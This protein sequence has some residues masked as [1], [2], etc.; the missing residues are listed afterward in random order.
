M[1]VFG[2]P[3]ILPILIGL[4]VASTVHPRPELTGK[5]LVTKKPEA[6]GPVEAAQLAENQF[7]R[8]LSLFRMLNPAS[9]FPVNAATVVA[10]VVG[11]CAWF[12]PA[13]W[14]WVSAAN[15]FGVMLLVAGWSAA[16]RGS[17]PNPQPPITW[18]AARAAAAG[19]RGRVIANAAGGACAGVSVAWLLGW[20]FASGPVVDVKAGLAEAVPGAPLEFWLPSGSGVLALVAAGV[21]G[22]VLMAARPVREAALGHWRQL[23]QM[24]EEW[25]ERWVA[26]KAASPFLEDFRELGEAVVLTFD[27]R[28]VTSSADVAG[29][30]KKNPAVFDQSRLTSFSTLPKL[31]DGNAPMPGTVDPRRFE[32]TQWPSDRLPAMHEIDADREQLTHVIGCALQAA[33][34]ATGQDPI[35]LADLIDLT[36]HENPGDKIWAATFYGSAGMPLRQT[37]APALGRQL[38]T[39]TLADHRAAGEAGVM[40][41][42]ALGDAQPRLDLFPAPSPDQAGS[43]RKLH[44]APE[45]MLAEAGAAELDKLALEDRWT[46]AWLSSLATNV[47]TPVTRHLYKETDTL[48]N[49]KTVERQAF[50]VRTGLTPPELMVPKTEAALASSRGDSFVSITSWPAGPFDGKPFRGFGK[51]PEKHATLFMVHTSRYPVPGIPDLAP[52]GD[53]SGPR[54]VLAGKLAKAFDEA[55][56]AR[57]EIQSCEPI[58]SQGSRKH[59]WRVRLWLYGGVTLADVRKASKKLKSSLDVAYLRIVSAPGGCEVIVGAD[60]NQRGIALAK[61]SHRQ[62]LAA[63]DWEEAFVEAGV[64]SAA[65]EPPTFISAAQMPH[66]ELVTR[67]V[68]KVPTGKSV[69][70]VRAAASKLRIATRNAFVD[71]RAEKGSP[72]QVQV[73][74]AEASPLRFP[75]PFRFDTDFQVTDSPFGTGVDGAPIALNRDR[76]AHL[77]IYGTSGGGKSALA[78]TLIVGCLLSGAQV[79]VAD[80]QKGAADFRFAEPWLSGTATTSNDVLALMQHLTDEKNR[81]VKLNSAHGCG[82]VRELPE[83]VRPPTVYFFIDEFFGIIANP[84]KPA[85]RP[86]DDPELEKARQELVAKLAVAKQ[87][88]YLTG[89]FAAEARSADIHLVVMTQKITLGMLDNSAAGP[90]ALNDLKTNLNAILLGKAKYGEKQSALRAPEDAPDVGEEVPPG[91]G[92]FEPVEGAAQIFQGWYATTAEYAAHLAARVPPSEPVDLSGY[93]G[94]I[95]KTAAPVGEFTVVDEDMSEVVELDFSEFDFTFDENDLEEGLGEPEPAPD[96]EDWMDDGDLVEIQEVADPGLDS[97]PTPIAIEV[98]GWGLG[99]PP[100]TPVSGPVAETV[101]EAGSEGAGAEPE[102]GAAADGAAVLDGGDELLPPLRKHRMLDLGDLDDVAMPDPLERLKAARQPT[103]ARMR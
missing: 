71:I 5:N 91:R 95:E 34:A 9:L 68:F 23:V 17:H 67:L 29:V 6:D 74:A 98:L 56:L 57:P 76:V 61:S 55:R 52:V 102:S 26:C 70:A 7:F 8:G 10:V 54:S 82:H 38:R 94:K 85:S 66:N 12:A 24:R 49:G 36:P 43:L 31:G 33:A 18:A 63:F 62:L 69:E 40:F 13:A 27:T 88:A 97:A 22:A 2:L 42:G 103:K 11:V 78:Q 25:R 79:Y 1:S 45:D 100:S 65:G 3:F 93:L 19:A 96:D 81:R 50:T 84:G 37:W 30:M 64:V 48:A 99:P 83:S 46:S 44:S 86:E 47:N 15:A 32:L 89:R 72:D 16:R 53:Q 80:I 87:I 92:I 14:L 59:L 90:G 51:S 75:E 101:S 60:P 73:L 35:L 21:A 28:G 39:P 4:Q 58:T 41:L 77:G 20:V